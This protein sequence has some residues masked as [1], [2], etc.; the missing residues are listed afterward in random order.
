MS[1]YKFCVFFWLVVV[2]FWIFKRKKQPIR[3]ANLNILLINMGFFGVPVF[4][5]SRAG[6][7]LSPRIR[8]FLYSD[9]VVKKFKH[10]FLVFSPRGVESASL[11][12]HVQYGYCNMTMHVF[13][14]QIITIFSRAI[15]W[16]FCVETLPSPCKSRSMCRLNFLLSEPVHVSRFSSS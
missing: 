12:L 14:F 10:I 2:R 6:K 4:H 9:W 3:D 13:I 7:E 11:L 15:T 5:I 8:I 1:L 16:L